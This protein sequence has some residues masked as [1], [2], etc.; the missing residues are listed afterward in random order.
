MTKSTKPSNAER[1]DVYE[2]VTARLIECIEQ[3]TRPWATP[4]DTSAPQAAAGR[5]IRHNGTPYQGINVLL[6]WAEALNKGYTATRWM[7]YRQASE[8]GGQVRAGERGALVVFANRVTRTTENEQGE[9]EERSLAVLKGYTVFNVEQIDG[10]PA[11]LSSGP[12]TPAVQKPSSGLAPA[13]AEFFARTGATVRLG[14]NKA[15]YS[16]GYDAIQLPPVAAFRDVHAFA[17][18][19]AHEL[20]HWTGH[21]DRLARE[22]GKRFGDEAYA[23]EELVAEVGAAFLCADLG[24]PSSVRDDHAAYVA[25][26]LKVLKSDKRAIF[27]AATQAQKAVDWLHGLQEPVQAA[28]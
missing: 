27:T 26:W 12:A 16:P 6:L 28:A 2:R 10:L 17:A 19:Q 1:V 3:G 23:V 21:P 4:W 7:T 15:F 11:D 24:V 8:L 25:S 9:E 22:F 18:T 14:G 5:P 20:I 13:V